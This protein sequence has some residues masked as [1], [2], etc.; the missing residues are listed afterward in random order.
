[1]NLIELKGVSKVYAGGTQALTDVSFAVNEGEFVSI[2]GPSGAG[3]ST[4]LRC[5]NRMIEPTEGEITFGGQNIL[6]TGKSE[7]RK[8]RRKIGMIFQHYNL[9][10]RLSLIENV[11]H[12]RLG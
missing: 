4:L 2:I 10:N 6:K 12:G 5:I 11:L 7:L 8:L 9:V 3:K 1:M